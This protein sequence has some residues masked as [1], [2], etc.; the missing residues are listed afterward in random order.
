MNILHV[1]YV[2]DDRR[3]GTINVRWNY[4]VDCCVHLASP[5]ATWSN[6]VGI[7]CVEMLRLFGQGLMPKGWLGGWGRGRGGEHGHCCNRLVHKLLPLFELI[8]H[9]LSPNIWVHLFS[10]IQRHYWKHLFF[11]EFFF[12]HTSTLS[13]QSSLKWICYWERSWLFFIS[14]SVSSL[15]IY[16]L[17][18][19]WWK[20]LVL[21]PVFEWICKDHQ[22]S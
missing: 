17:V 14:Y 13:T 5:S 7:C 8:S 20:Q 9:L 19:F 1:I 11:T 22:Q 4:C 18:M 6:N 12:L 3:L 15:I 10:K 21:Q 16:W 2:R